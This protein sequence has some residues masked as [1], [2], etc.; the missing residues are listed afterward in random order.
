MKKM[1]KVMMFVFFAAVTLAGAVELDVNGRVEAK[2]NSGY[3]W[4]GQLLNEDPVFQPSL[5][6]DLND[7]V[8]IFAWGTW[9][10]PNQEGSSGRDRVDLSI[11]LSKNF[12]RHFFKGGAVAYIYNDSE[13][14]TKEDTYE[15]FLGYTLDV[16]ALPTLRVYYDF[17]EYETFFAVFSL[18]GSRPIVKDKVD[19]EW[20]LSIE[21]G[22]E[23]YNRIF[24]FDPATDETNT[25]SSTGWKVADVSAV[26]QM[27]VSFENGWTLIPGLTYYS[28]VDQDVEDA[29]KILDLKKDEFIFST[30]LEYV[31]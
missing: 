26:L 5:R 11:S 14:T 24:H 19:L 22:D 29:F 10:L 7:E 28:V 9:D 30:A 17:G 20:R 21:G 18:A 3:M 25:F 8:N 23:K 15:V 16:P 1:M 13:F 31:F 2:I 4:R 12:D 6:L 27:P